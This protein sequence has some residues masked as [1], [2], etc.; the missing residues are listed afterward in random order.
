VGTGLG[1]KNRWS[2][3]DAMGEPVGARSLRSGISCG[4]LMLLFLYKNKC[5][6]I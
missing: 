6:L 2:T 4:S 1:T 3:G 5:G